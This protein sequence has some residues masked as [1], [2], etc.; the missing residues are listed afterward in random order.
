[1]ARDIVTAI[2]DMTAL[3]WSERACSSGTAGTYLKARSGS[4]M[5]MVYYKLS[6]YNGLEIDGCE[7]VN[8]L[9]ASRLMQI[10]GMEHLTYRL[11]HAKVAIDGREHE[12]WLN[13]SKNFRGRGERKLGLGTFFELYHREGEAP[14]DFCVRYGWEGKVKQMMLVDYLIANRDR[15]SSNVEV[16]VQRDGSARLAPLFDSGLSLLAP[17][18]ADEGRIA[19]F[20]PLRPVA[21]TNFIG[22]RSLEEN[23]LH[24]VPVPDV[25]SLSSES[26]GQLM[27][28]LDRVLSHAH[29]DKIWE[30][31]WRRWEHYEEIRDSRQ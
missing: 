10:L 26:K 6:R 5:R 31:I 15:H 17:Y 21:T 1:M 27:H 12:T 22:S 11:V 18:A 13:A 25:N 14:Y 16:L 24:A 2:Q 8:E 20:D 28:G 30:M 9:V 4:G 29:C 7:C 3:S 23:L 19:S